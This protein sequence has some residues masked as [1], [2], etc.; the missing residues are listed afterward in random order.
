MSNF[1]EFF[2]SSKHDKQHEAVR[3][4]ISALL[5]EGKSL[6][7]KREESLTSYDIQLLKQELK[8]RL[9]VSILVF[10]VV[11]GLFIW[12]GSGFMI[13]LGAL[14]LIAIYPIVRYQQ[15]DMQRLF[16][17][18]KKEVIRGIITKSESRVSGSGKNRTT[19]YYLQL[20]DNEF[21]VSRTRYKKYK[22]G[23]AAEFHTVE[24]P[25]RVTHILFEEKLEQAGLN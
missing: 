5:A 4:K 16:N 20:G 23:D 18:N 13:I 2:R 19:R 7:L 22:I 10:A 11:G 6:Y 3:T 15:K 12:L 21:E 8:T 1:F 14:L 9:I 24:Y 25:K 17:D